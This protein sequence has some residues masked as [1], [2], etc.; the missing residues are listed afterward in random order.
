MIIIVQKFPS[1]ETER[2]RL[3]ELK[4]TDIPLIVKY[5]GNQNISKTTLN[6]PNPYEEKDA[7]FWI[8]MSQQGFKNKTQFTFGVELKMTN[9]LI[10]G[11]GLILNERFNRAEAGYWIA[12]PFWN[13]G[14]CSEVLKELLRF[15][16]KEL[17]LNKIFATHLL[18]NAAS[19]RVMEKNGM[20]KEGV[21]IDH[22]KKGDTYFS[23]VQYRLTKSEYESINSN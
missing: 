17:K 6:I 19:G 21:L 1:L 8:N 9:N 22:A 15:G 13:N 2:L 20:I 11:T 10:G 3:R 16:F 14:Y 7:I 23:L 12:E 18:E 5:A 4:A